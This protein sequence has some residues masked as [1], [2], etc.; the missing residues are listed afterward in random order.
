MT[1]PL[2]LSPSPE[3]DREEVPHVCGLNQREVDRLSTEEVLVHSQGEV[4][5]GLKSPKVRME[6]GP[7]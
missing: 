7:G 3:S 2:C 1:W 6:T 5:Q 4:N